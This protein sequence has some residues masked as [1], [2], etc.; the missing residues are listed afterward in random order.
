MQ[1]FKDVFRD[2]LWNGLPLKQVVDHEINTG[3]K[4]PSN[5]NAYPLSVVQLE[6][7]TKEINNL[8]KRR[9]IQESTSSWGAPVLFIRKPKVSGEWRMCIDYRA[10]NQKMLKN[11]YPLPRIQDYLIQLGKGSH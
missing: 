6:E 5:Q 11:A 2:E 4:P 7:Q 9:L 10:L 1:E 3:N 8:F